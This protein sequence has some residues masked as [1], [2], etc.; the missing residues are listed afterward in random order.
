[1]KM[2]IGKRI[3]LFFHWLLSLLIV[4]AFA[5]YLIVP[6]FLMKYYDKLEGAVGFTYVK[7][8]GIAL[9]A[10][11]VVLAAFVLAMIFKRKKK[12]EAARKR[13]YN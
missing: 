9:L 5:V 1:M 4:A 12:S 7:V 8:I 10:V 11:Y 6:D 2:S 13:K 3:L